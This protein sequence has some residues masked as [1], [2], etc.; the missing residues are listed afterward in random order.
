MLERT[1]TSTRLDDAMAAVKR[2]LGSNAVILSSRSIDAS[3]D[4]QRRFEVVA[5]PAAAVDP[6]RGGHASFERRLVRK[7]V[8]ATLARRIVER[9]PGD[10]GRLG[11]REPDVSELA[12]ALAGELGFGTAR[13]DARVVALVGPTGVG[14][15]T[16]VAKLAAI[17]ALVDRRPTALVS[18]DHFRVGAAEQLEC[19]AEL[20]GV[21]LEVAHDAPS[22][23][24]ALRRLHDADAVIIDTAGR[25]PR[26]AAA[27]AALA[28]ALRGVDEPVD[29][30]LCLPAS[31][32]QSEL[33][34]VIAR[35]APLRPDGVVATKV[36]EAVYYG[37]IVAA[38]HLAKAPLVDLT[39]GQRVPE[40]IAPATPNRLAEL[41]LGEGVHE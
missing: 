40:D 39:V 23:E 27:I 30:R 6:R 24:I 9:L 36:D 2:D 5:A 22:L 4:E 28:D 21:P 41:L 12:R 18:M 8:P 10:V 3:G 38:G 19:Y 17:A 37:A 34:A 16:T 13:P 25:S 7:G 1:Y 11:T 26:D 32:R 14:K 15:T 35:H 33:E 20:V 29:V 31:S